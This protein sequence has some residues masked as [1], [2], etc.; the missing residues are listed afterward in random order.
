MLAPTPP[1]RLVDAQGRPYFL[2]DCEITLAELE[3]RLVDPDPEVRAYW[4]GKTMREAKP[5]DAVMLIPPPVMRAHWDRLERFLGRTR[6][7]WA[8]LLLDRWEKQCRVG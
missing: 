8:W 3:A 4:M 1:D 6:P 2:W 5:D 7:F